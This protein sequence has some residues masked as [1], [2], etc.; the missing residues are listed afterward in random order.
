MPSGQCAVARRLQLRG[1]SRHDPKAH[2]V[3]V[4]SGQA[5]TKACRVLPRA[6]PVCQARR[7]AGSNLSAMRAIS[8][9]GAER[10]FTARITHASFSAIKDRRV[11]ISLSAG[12]HTGQEA[13]RQPCSASGRRAVA[14]AP[15][16]RRAPFG[17]GAPLSRISSGAPH[18][19]RP[20]LSGAVDS[21]TPGCISAQSGGISQRIRIGV[22][23]P[24]KGK[25]V[26][27]SP[28]R[29][30]VERTTPFARGLRPG[31]ET[32]PHGSNEGDQP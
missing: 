7:M 30:V 1:Q 9:C 19:R 32:D 25:P 23:G 29:R 3:P 31:T 5:G 13:G 18:G 4:S 22:G 21:G 11:R 17:R 27:R 16:S 26:A 14:R 8:P 28:A 12:R 20:D 24:R 6:P 10:G 2:R 15:P